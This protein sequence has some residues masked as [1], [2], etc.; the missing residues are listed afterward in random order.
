MTLTQ[1][2]IILQRGSVSEWQE[3]KTL[4]SSARKNALRHSPLSLEA[5]SFTMTYSV[6][7]IHLL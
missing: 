3:L 5:E 4:D 1:T 2:H 6:R 7:G